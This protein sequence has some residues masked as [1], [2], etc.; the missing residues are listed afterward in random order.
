MAALLPPPP[1]VF[2]QCAAQRSAAQCP[3]LQTFHTC[4]VPMADAI[5]LTMHNNM[6]ADMMTTKTADSM[7]IDT[8]AHHCCCR[9]H[10]HV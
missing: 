4:T 1:T 5:Q 8:S 7:R 2:N 6:A 3:H 10:T 9:Q